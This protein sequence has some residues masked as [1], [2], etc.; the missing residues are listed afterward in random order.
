[1]SEEDRCKIDRF[2]EQHTSGEP[3][4]EEAEAEEAEAEEE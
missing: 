1:M 2:V 3:E 4:E